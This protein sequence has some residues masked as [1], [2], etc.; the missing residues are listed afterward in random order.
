MTWTLLA[1]AVMWLNL[2]RVLRLVSLD[3][4]SSIKYQWD[5]VAVLSRDHYF[6]G[7]DISSDALCCFSNDRHKENSF[8]LK[9]DLEKSFQETPIYEV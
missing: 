9:E 3:C 1:A 6:N 4:K 2:F 5:N 8:D 7:S